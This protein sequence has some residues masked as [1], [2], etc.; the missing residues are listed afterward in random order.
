MYALFSAEV[1][2]R[3]KPFGDSFTKPLGNSIVFT[4]EVTG[5]V[6]DGVSY[7]LRWLD[8]N[9]QEITERTGR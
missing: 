2:L 4:C 1:E 3:L 8:K 6:R 9:D 7:N 5:S